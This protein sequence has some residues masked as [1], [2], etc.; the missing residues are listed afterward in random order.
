[1]FPN[2]SLAGIV[3]V[4]LLVFGVP[5]LIAGCLIGGRNCVAIDAYRYQWIKN[6]TTLETTESGRKVWVFNADWKYAGETLDSVVDRE[7][8]IKP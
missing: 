7:A 4:C 1:M 6:K 3:S 5:C 2:I 8:A